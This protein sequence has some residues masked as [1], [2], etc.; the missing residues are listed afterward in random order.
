MIIHEEMDQCSPEWFEARNGIVT[1]SQF[2]RI[3]SEK[4]KTKYDLQ[5]DLSGVKEDSELNKMKFSELQE[6]ATKNE[7]ILSEW[8]ISDCTDIAA[9]LA[10]EILA[11]TDPDPWEG[12][13]HMEHGKDAEDEAIRLYEAETGAKCKKVGFITNDEKTAGCSPDRLVGDDGL[14]EVK[15]PKAKNMI[16]YYT[17]Y[18][19]TGKC[20]ADFYLQI[21]GQLKFSERM[22]CDLVIFHWAIGIKIIRVFPD[23]NAHEKIDDAISFVNQ[24]R[25]EYVVKMS[26][27]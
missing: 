11:N 6:L 17:E 10:A 5:S 1:A 26:G 27:I 8:T 9:Q 16:K 3:L 12:N 20:P 15:S 23:L 25:D 24:L 4:K 21:Q 2:S 14:A 7:I 13:S 19:E 18:L 22:W